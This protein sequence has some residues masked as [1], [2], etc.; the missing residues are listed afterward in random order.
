[1]AILVPTDGSDH[2]HKAVD[3][4][5][6]LAEKHGS[7]VLLLHVL[8]R[9]KEPESLARL[10]ETERLSDGLRGELARLGDREVAE[11][12]PAEVY[13]RDPNHVERPLPEGLLM[14]VGDGILDAACRQAEA[15]GVVARRLAI[16]D[17]E[18]AARILA[19][20]ER[21]AV[22]TIVMGSRG[23]REIDAMTFG[24]VS[25][26]VTRDSPCTCISIK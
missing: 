20:V 3:L 11:D 14:A 1:M 8:L 16:E 12:V 18:L 6:D 5:C 23:L 24:S 9:D 21:E 17:G 15:R 10:A 2:A 19:C 4:A 25:H 22:E 26:R 13:M 7:A